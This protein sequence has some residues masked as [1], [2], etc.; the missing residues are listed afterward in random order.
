MREFLVG[1]RSR[2]QE[3][4]LVA[5]CEAPDDACAAN[6][7]ARNRDEVCKFG[8]EDAVE[9]FACADGGQGVGIGECREDADPTWNRIIS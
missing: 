6:G 7:A 2:N 1:R 9:V 5:G 4:I 8:F 3:T